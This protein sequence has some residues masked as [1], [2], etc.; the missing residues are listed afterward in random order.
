MDC[1]GD[2]DHDQAAAMVVID[3][4]GTQHLAASPGTMARDVQHSSSGKG[5]VDVGVVEA[6]AAQAAETIRL[7]TVDQIVPKS[8]PATDSAQR[9][10]KVGHMHATCM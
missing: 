5:S 8:V 2:D 6:L 7:Q 3:L 10:H 1:D 4:I 9:I